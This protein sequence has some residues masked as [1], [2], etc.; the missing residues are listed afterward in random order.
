[1]D[2]ERTDELNRA[3]HSAYDFGLD[4]PHRGLLGRISAQLDGSPEPKG[5]SL[6][7]AGLATLVLAVL[8]VGGLIW[9]SKLQS[10]TSTPGRTVSPSRG[11]A[12]DARGG[13]AAAFDPANGNFV[14]FGGSRGSSGALLDDTWVHDARAWKHVAT[15]VHPS[16]RFSSAAADDDAHHNLVLFGGYGGSTSGSGSSNSPLGDTWIWTGQSWTQMHPLTSPSPR[17]GHAMA[18]DSFRGQVVLY[19]GQNGP[20]AVLNDTWAWDG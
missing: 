4:F 19:G 15:D 1:L 6:R 17:F 11:I 3:L 13:A 2:D 9:I 20:N 10:G 14:L 16:A 7:V 12:P 18:Y 5:N 8:V